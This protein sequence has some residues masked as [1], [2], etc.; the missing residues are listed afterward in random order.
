MNKNN[1]VKKAV[2]WELELEG[3]PDFNMAMKRIYAWFDGEI[4]D[5]APV[6]FSSHNSF[7]HN[8]YTDRTWENSKEKW[9]DVE[10]QIG[11]YIESIKGK[12]FLGET[13]PIYWPN[14]GPNVFAAFY[15]CDLEFA[16]VTSWAVPCI[17]DW[18]DINNLQLDLN[19]KYF[20][21]IEELTR[22]A[23]DNCEDRFI[24]GYTDLHPGVDCVA[25]WRDTQNLC[26]DLYDNYEEV[27][28]AADKA[29]NDFQFIYDHFDALLKSKNQLS[30]TW[31]EIPSFGK[32]H[33]PSCDFS[34]MISS[35]QF[36]DLCLPIIQKEVK[37]MTHNIF[38][39]DGKDCAR[40][41]DIILEVPE[42]QAI[43]WVQGAGDKPI[44]QWVPLIK[45]IQAAGKS[46]V[47]DL[48][49]DELE[50]FISSV[51]PKGIML[52]LPVNDEKDQRQILR[53]IEKWK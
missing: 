9:F 41:L 20:K 16:E 28:S 25:A 45:K 27:K 47:V 8:I 32:M 43:Q 21:K 13:F 1:N 35:N 4:I 15:G 10:F 42:I 34:S 23:L 44:M 46:V 6:R 24:V 31:M 38:H 50:S 2:W 3:K 18:H 48:E 17:N 19:N 36:I 33:I 40:H 52:C 29:I 39:L 12:N 53:R 51:D 30:V 26:Y 49:V 37:Q 22:Y 7:V 14:L 5:R 11:S